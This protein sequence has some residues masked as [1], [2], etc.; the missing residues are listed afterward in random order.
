M[1][2]SIRWRFLSWLT[3]I[4]LVTITGFGASLFYLVRHSKLQE[5]DTELEGAAIV[6]VEKL[7]TFNV[8]SE[9]ADAPPGRS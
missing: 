7:R 9:L 3:L 1:F 8:E 4:L 2:K 6:L 5:T